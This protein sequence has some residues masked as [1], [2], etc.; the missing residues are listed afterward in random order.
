MHGT[1]CTPLM[2][3]GITPGGNAMRGGSGPTDAEESISL[4][5]AMELESVPR[6][7]K[8]GNNSLTEGKDEFFKTVTSRLMVHAGNRKRS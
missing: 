8:T 7:R 2:G 5:S 4:S 1:V 6:S 3:G